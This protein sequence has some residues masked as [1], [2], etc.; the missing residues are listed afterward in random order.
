MVV[1]LCLGTLYFGAIALTFAFI[2]LPIVAIF[3][4]VP[5]GTLLDQLSNPVV[6]DALDDQPQERSSSPRS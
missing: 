1:R 6:T 5:I 2:V 4:H 3:F